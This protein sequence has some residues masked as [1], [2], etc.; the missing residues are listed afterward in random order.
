MPTSTYMLRSRCSHDR[1]GSHDH[2]I[3]PRRPRGRGAP[4]Q[5]RTHVRI[6][7]RIGSHDHSIATPTPTWARH[8]GSLERTCGY[9]HEIGSYDDFDRPSP[10]HQRGHVAPRTG[11][12][13]ISLWPVT[14]DSAGSMVAGRSSQPRCSSPRSHSGFLCFSERTFSPLASC[15]ESEAP[16]IERATDQRQTQRRYAVTVFDV[17]SVWDIERR[18]LML[19]LDFS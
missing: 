4:R 17:T 5:P 6:P 8:R 3:A 7:C 12:R 16:L 15:W 11:S 1:F 13:E 18:I 2:S 9:P 14:C 19:M 10:R